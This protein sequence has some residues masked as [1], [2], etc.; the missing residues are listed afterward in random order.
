MRDKLLHSSLSSVLRLTIDDE[1]GYPAS[2]GVIVQRGSKGYL[3]TYHEPKL[4]SLVHGIGIETQ[5][6]STSDIEKRTREN[7]LRLSQACKTLAADLL[8]HAARLKD[9]AKKEQLIHDSTIDDIPTP[10]SP[11]FTP[12]PG[13]NHANSTPEPDPFD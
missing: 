12:A 1:I 3:L 4:S 8:S 5:Y 13:K 2:I 11:A 7:L 10:I 9:E 6:A